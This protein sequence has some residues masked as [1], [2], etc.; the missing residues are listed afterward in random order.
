MKKLL[1]L[2]CVVVLMLSGCGKDDEAPNTPDHPTEDV[3]PETPDEPVIPEEEIP[4][5]M[6]GVNIYHPDEEFMKLMSTAVD[7]ESFT[8]D[9]LMEKIVEY[10]KFPEGMK[11][12][13]MT[14][15]TE[16]DKVVISLDLSEDF[17]TYILTMGTSGEFFAIQSI[18]NSFVEAFNA[19]GVRLTVSGVTLETGHNIY[20][21]VLT[22]TQE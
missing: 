1:L 15:G 13:S 12:L 20:D 7:F 10:N 8:A 6:R 16:H 11:V 22:F 9:A 2:A 18:V 3:T 21:Y 17:R 14:Q 19:D 5:P 4:G